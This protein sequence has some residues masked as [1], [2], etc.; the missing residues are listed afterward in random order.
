MTQHIRITGVRRQPEPDW[1]K[2][3]DALL[4][5]AEEWARDE[6]RTQEVKPKEKRE[7]KA[8][9]A[10]LLLF[11]GGLSLPASILTVRWLDA[12]R[13]ARTVFTYRLRFPRQL[14]PSDVEHFLRGL[15]GVASGPRD[16]L[17]QPHIVFE[18]TATSAGITHH[19]I[20]DERLVPAVAVQLRA[21]MGDVRLERSVTIKHSTRPPSSSS[22]RREQARCSALRSQRPRVLPCWRRYNR[23]ETTRKFDCSGCCA[24]PSP[25]IASATSA[26]AGALVRPNLRQRSS[27]HYASAF[28]HRRR[29]VAST[30]SGG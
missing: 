23:F 17:G 20:A 28:E 21:Q 14:R 19:L 22:A 29:N 30:S 10:L 2:F 15:T 9:K 27:E 18:L 11:I 7:N 8:I 12:R 6:A 26:A 5:L 3:I 13:L 16:F 4:V 24:R 25:T 1:A